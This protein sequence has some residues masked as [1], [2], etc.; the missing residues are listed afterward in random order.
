MIK[1]SLICHTLPLSYWFV[2]ATLWSFK[3]FS[4]WHLYFLLESTFDDGSAKAKCYAKDAPVLLLELGFF[5]LCNSNFVQMVRDCEAGPG[6]MEICFLVK[7][8]WIAMLNMLPSEC[9]D[10]L[11]MH[12]NPLLLHLS[13][14]SFS[15][16]TW[17]FLLL[18]CF[19]WL[20]P[21]RTASCHL[22]FCSCFR[23][24]YK[25]GDDLKLTW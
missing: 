24:S 10:S 7:S 21:F 22:L 12:W 9:D 11:W 23:W 19:R 1:K 17:T 4:I 6:H 20:S 8:R 3:F 16:F 15:A 2:S 5:L 25:T 18:V 13:E 14:A